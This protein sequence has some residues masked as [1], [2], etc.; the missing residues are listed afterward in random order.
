M[1]FK[2]LNPVHDTKE[3]KTYIVG[4]I[5]E[6]KDERLDEI[7]SKLSEQGGLELYLEEIQV[8]ESEVSTKKSDKKNSKKADKEVTEE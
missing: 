7:K 8:V 4:D 5:F 2:V 6:V 3:N 1:K